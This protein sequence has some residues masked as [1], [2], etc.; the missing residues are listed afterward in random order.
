MRIGTGIVLL[1]VGAVLRFAITLPNPVIDLGVAGAILMGA[2]LVALALGIFV[3]LRP[4][5][6]V[7][8]VIRQPPE[9]L[10]PTKPYNQP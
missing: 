5:S 9:S 8:T 10:P 1:V 7:T 3:A 4:K 2:G 6:T